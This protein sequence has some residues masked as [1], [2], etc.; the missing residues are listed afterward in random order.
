MA[1]IKLEISVDE[2]QEIVTLYDRLEIFRAPNELGSPVPYTEITANDLT[3]A[4]MDGSNSGPWNLNGTSL[5]ISIDNADPIV[6]NF[7]GTNPFNLKE[8]IDIINSHFPNLTEEVPTD[9]NRIRFTSP[10]EGTQSTL[11]IGGTARS[12]LGFGTFLVSGKGPRLLLAL[13][14]ELYRF[15]DFTGLTTDWYKTRFINS[16]TGALSDFSA[17]FL[18]GDGTG[19]TSN[20]L[21]K[22]S[23]ALSDLSGAPI[24]GRRIIFVPTAPQVINDGI[25]HNYGILP[26]VDRITVITDRN[27]RISI[28]LVKGQRLKVFIEGTT[29]QREFIVPTTDFDILTVASTQPDPLNIVNTIPFA[30]RVS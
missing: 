1:I 3:P 12:V 26:S 20:F 24:V 2:I 11:I 28:F 13:S 17:P 27:G 8:T 16:I 18:G 21:V 22:G 14:T 10:S 25:G 4:I 29:F 7:T 15:I 23:I 30:L 6:I 5:T 19:L 9:T